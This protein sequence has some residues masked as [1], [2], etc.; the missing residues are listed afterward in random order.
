MLY[1]GLVLFSALIVVA[2]Q[3]SKY[4]VTQY[5]VLGQTLPTID[6]VLELHYVRNSGMAWSL[7]SGGEAR[8]LFVGLTIVLLIFMVVIVWKKIFTNKFELF[9]LAAIMGGAIGNFIDRLLTGEV[10]DMLQFAFIDF[11]VFNVADCFITC[12]SILLAVYLVFFDRAPKQKE[13]ADDPEK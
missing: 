5:M 4:F 13:P 7:L 6:G 8:W 11:P 9:C 12:G 3:L 2:D 10:V 1:A